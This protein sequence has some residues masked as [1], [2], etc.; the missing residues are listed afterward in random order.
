MPLRIATFNLENL[1]DVQGAQPTLAERIAVMR[2]QLNR[3]RADVLCLQEVHSQ[4]PAGARTLAALGVLNR[5]SMT[6]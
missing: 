6:V 3:V 4:G 2:P 1:D 5:R